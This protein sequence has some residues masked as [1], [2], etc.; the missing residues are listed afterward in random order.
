[1]L[2][3][4]V[5]GRFLMPGLEPLDAFGFE[6]RFVEGLA[7]GWRHALVLEGIQEKHRS[8]SDRRDGIAGVD[9]GRTEAA[10]GQSQRS[11]ADALFHAAK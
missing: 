2:F 10:S 4:A 1:M 11:P 3:M 5:P 8:G 9:F 6:G 7:G